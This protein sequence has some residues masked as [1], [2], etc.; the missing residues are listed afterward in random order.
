V[1]STKDR[2]PT[3]PEHLQKQLWGYMGGRHSKKP[4]EA[5]IVSIGGIEGPCPHIA[6]IAIGHRTFQI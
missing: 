1:F 2:Q 3:I 4:Y 5:A 6:V